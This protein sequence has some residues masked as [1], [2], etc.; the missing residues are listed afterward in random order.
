MVQG[1]WPL[2]TSIIALFKSG[3][4]GI[5]IGL[6][7]SIYEAR[8]PILPRILWHEEISEGRY[9]ISKKET[10][11]CILGIITFITWICTTVVFIIIASRS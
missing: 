11:L 2:E 7:Y 10:I 1:N 3:G 9:V 4:V 5:V 8:K 6:L